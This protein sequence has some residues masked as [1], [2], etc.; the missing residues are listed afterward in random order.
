[1]INDYWIVSLFVIE[2]GFGIA[3][4]FRISIGK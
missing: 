3:E 4:D 2:C 1:M